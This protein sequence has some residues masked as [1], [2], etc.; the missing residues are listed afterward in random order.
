L[1]GLGIVIKVVASRR[2]NK[3]QIKTGFLLISLIKQVIVLSQ[4]HRGISNSLGQG[5]DSKRKT[6]I[7]LQGQIDELIVKGINNGLN[8]FP[9]WESFVEYWPRLKNYVLSDKLESRNLLRQHNIMIEGHLSLF[10]DVARYYKLHT[11]MLDNI[12]HASE[13]CLD[14]LRT[15]EMIG[16]A[17]AVGAGICAKGMTEGVDFIALNFL[18]I[19]LANST[20]EL[21]NAL[22]NVNN[23]KLSASLKNAAG[24]IRDRAQRLVNTI[25]NQVL[26]DG[27]ISLDSKDYF[28]TATQPIDELLKVFTSIENFTLRQPN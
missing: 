11:I 18:K 12:T 16:Q 4:Q 28:A 26:I 1:T 22:S 19:S 15:A 27:V 10:D 24:S 5:N 25:E 20:K 21:C 14:T 13:L 8:K 23:S 6:L 17:R 3:D 2:K 7:S 9:Q